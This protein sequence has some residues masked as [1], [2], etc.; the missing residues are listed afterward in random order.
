MIISTRKAWKSGERM[1]VSKTKAI[2]EALANVR[3]TR[4]E[5]QPRVLE[6]FLKLNGFHIAEMPP[7]EK[8]VEKKNADG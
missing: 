1:P 2:Q 6:R 4:V 5:D 8:F 7:Q 3:R